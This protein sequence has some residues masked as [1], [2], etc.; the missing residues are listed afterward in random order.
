MSA[1]L[2]ELYK[3]IEKYL[4]IMNLHVSHLQL[5]NKV[6]TLVILIY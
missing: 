4:F 3:E 1:S 5:L 2:K 6:F